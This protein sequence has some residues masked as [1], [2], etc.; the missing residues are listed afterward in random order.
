MWYQ[1]VFYNAVYAILLYHGYQTPGIYEVML[2]AY[3]ESG[4]W[5]STPTGEI[6]DNNKLMRGHVNK[7]YRK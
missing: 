5:V 1:L 3:Y 7:R 2:D 6:G 4:F